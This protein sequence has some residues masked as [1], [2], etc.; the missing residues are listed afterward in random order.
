METTTVLQLRINADDVPRGFYER[1]KNI[2]DNEIIDGKALY[3]SDKVR[4]AHINYRKSKANNDIIQKLA[5]SAALS[6]FDVIRKPLDTAIQNTIDKIVKQEVI[7][8]GGKWQD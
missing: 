4:Q 1:Y 5:A 8:S 7:K 6:G 2:I 3:S